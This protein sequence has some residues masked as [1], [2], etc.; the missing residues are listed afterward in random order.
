VVANPST[1][2]STLPDIDVTPPTATDRPR[3][4]G[5]D[6]RTVTADDAQAVARTLAQA[7]WDDPHFRWIVRDDGR[8][9][10]RLERGFATF[11]RRVWLPHGACYTHERLS[12]AAMWLPPGEWH[13]SVFAQLALLPAV[14]RAMGG[15]SPRLM[16]ALTFIER[17]HPHKPH[18]Y[19]PVIGVAPAWQG[20][21]Y[22]ASLLR[23]VLDR[24]DADR[25]PAYL[26][27]SS[28][29]NRALYERHGFESIEE[30]TYAG[31]AP[32]L[33]RMWREPRG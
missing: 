16:R 17:K 9:L 27:A 18:W 26:E 33:W 32:P 23:P 22:G 14:V 15:D 20:R 5:S 10:S 25:V 4:D 19:L 24:C 29:R 28:P 8:R 11:T 6:I 1:E 31:D 3:P 13:L 2:D 7:F 21:G 12:G 30:C